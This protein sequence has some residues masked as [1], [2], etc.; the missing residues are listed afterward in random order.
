MTGK[1]FVGLDV[2]ARSVNLCV[3]D[4][5]GRVVHERRMSVDPDAIAAHIQSLALD[6]ER[7]GLE[8]GMLSQH[9]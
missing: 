3:V 1:H 2:S 4:A 9:L 6:I 8:A 5:D 7:V